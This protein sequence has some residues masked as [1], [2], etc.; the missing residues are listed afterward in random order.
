MCRRQVGR[1]S[2]CRDAHTLV[3]ATA[4][5]YDLLQAH[6]PHACATEVPRQARMRLVAGSSFHLESDA[7][8]GR[9]RLSGRSHGYDATPASSGRRDEYGTR[10]ST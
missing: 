8:V 1:A 9:Q 6:V 4:R 5:K 10:P 3:P 7:S 2:R